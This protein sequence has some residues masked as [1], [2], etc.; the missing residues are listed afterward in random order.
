MKVVRIPLYLT[1]GV[2]TFVQG[3]IAGLLFDVFR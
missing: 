3:V 2:E 1:G